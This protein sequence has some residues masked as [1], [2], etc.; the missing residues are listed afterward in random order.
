VKDHHTG[1][2]KSQWEQRDGDKV[3]GSYSVLEPDGSIRTVDYTAD[4]HNGFNAVVKRTGPSR[5]PVSKH[6]FS[7]QHVVEPF[8]SVSDPISPIISIP[9]EVLPTKSTSYIPQVSDYSTGLQFLR[10]G[11]QY[12]SPDIDGLSAYTIPGGINSYD[13]PTYSTQALHA[14]DSELAANP[15][16]VL[17]PETPE[18]PENGS[19]D[20]KEATLSSGSVQN[21]EG[22]QDLAKIYHDFFRTRAGRNG[23]V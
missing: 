8:H 23:R 3:K 5:H 7:S 6:V 16:P 2:L 15:G 1:D 21:R 14:S 20:Q 11:K 18:E 22:T 4:D 9:K 17:F 12:Y 10:T 13:S 19:S